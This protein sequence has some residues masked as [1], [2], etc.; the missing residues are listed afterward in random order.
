M[1]V[2]TKQVYGIKYYWNHFKSQWEG[3][4]DNGSHIPDRYFSDVLLRLKKGKDGSLIE[5]LK[6]S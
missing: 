2:I 4:K 6:I 5:Y 1:Y 3:L